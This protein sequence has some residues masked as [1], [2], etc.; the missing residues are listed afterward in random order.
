MNLIEMGEL[1]LVI[2]DQYMV[3][4]FEQDNVVKFI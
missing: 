1:S 2:Q 4:A 3:K